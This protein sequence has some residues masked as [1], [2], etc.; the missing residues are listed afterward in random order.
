[1][2]KSFYSSFCIFPPAFHEIVCHFIRRFILFHKQQIRLFI[3]RF[4]TVHSLKGEL[5]IYPNVSP[6]TFGCE[7]ICLD[8]F[9]RIQCKFCPKGHKR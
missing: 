5:F 8:F 3:Y 7:N 1:M 9:I 4:F 6:Y 2:I